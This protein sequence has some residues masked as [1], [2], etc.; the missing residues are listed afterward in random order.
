MKKKIDL[1][2]FDLDGT[3]ID[4]KVDIVSSV[5]CALSALGLPERNPAEIAGF[6]GKGV[7]QLMLD[8]LGERHTDR[9]NEAAA[10][11]KDIYRAHMFDTTTLYPNVAE[12]L[13][14]F[15]DK[16]KTI[17]S[18][19]SAEFIQLALERFGI[20]RY[21]LKILGGD[22]ENYRK[23]SPFPLINLIKEFNTAKEK[24]IIVGDSPLDVESGRAAGILTCGVTYGI[25]RK[26]EVTAAGPDFI[27]DDIG[28]LKGAIE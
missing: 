3:L 25:G 17:A 21:F 8:C 20:E 14:I 2:I 12:T 13:R 7:R 18:N 24:T 27:I 23:P 26:E 15:K 11:Y 22:D 1:I 10:I 9:L 19:K 28:K 6:I 5:I 16:K 4:S